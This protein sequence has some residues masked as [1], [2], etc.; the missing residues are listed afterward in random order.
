MRLE[1]RGDWSKYPRAAE[2]AADASSLAVAERHIRHPHR[3]G[4][5]RF[6]EAHRP[7]LLARFRRPDVEGVSRASSMTR[8]GLALLIALMS[9]G[10][11]SCTT[12]S[13][14]DHEAAPQAA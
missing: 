5:A 4:D 12:R 8:D 7:S 3:A 14:R 6:Q 11:G 9:C 1:A 13:V 10:T 2:H